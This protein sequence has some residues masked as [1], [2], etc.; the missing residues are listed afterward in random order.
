MV[1]S[2]Q[3]LQD[4]TA[5][6]AERT[7]TGSIM[8]PTHRCMLEAVLAVPYTSEDF[9][10]SAKGWASVLNTHSSSGSVLAG[11]KSRYRYFSV[12]ASQNDCILLS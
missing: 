2:R 6:A 4:R 5:A 3:G 10:S 11:L 12:S 9:A 8:L 7:I 1:G